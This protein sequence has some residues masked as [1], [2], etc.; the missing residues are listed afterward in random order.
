[1]Y[2]IILQRKLLPNMSSFIYFTSQINLNSN[3]NIIW[4]CL[5]G[6]QLSFTITC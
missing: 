5:L 3:Q 2:Y 4:Q 6:L 1:M